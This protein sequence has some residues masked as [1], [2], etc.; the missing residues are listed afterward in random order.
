MSRLTAYLIIPL[1][2]VLFS[3]DG[4]W[5]T[6]NFS[7]I[8]SQMEKQE[9]FVFWG[10]AVGLYFYWAMRKIFALIA[11]KT[12][13]PPKG[14]WLVPLA[15]VLLTFA[16]T[17]PYL[18][19]QFPLKAFLH[20]IFAFVSALCLIGA[21]LLAAWS[22]YRQNPEKYRPFLLFLAGIMS[23]SLI[24]LWLCGIV[25]SALEVCFIISSAIL[26]QKLYESCREPF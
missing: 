10:L 3:M 16:L 8:G 17:T 6:S 1:I 9:R 25:S 11:L 21:M 18:P 12:E 24:L 14:A 26:V 7:V 22:L 20:V 23:F 13:K 15:L 4:N 2:T 19:G 5:F